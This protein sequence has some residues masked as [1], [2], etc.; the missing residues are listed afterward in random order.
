MLMH[1]PH[2]TK[3]S[4]LMHAPRITEIDILMH[5]PVY[6]SDVTAF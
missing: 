5:L 1:V 6:V 2:F 4:K 3:I